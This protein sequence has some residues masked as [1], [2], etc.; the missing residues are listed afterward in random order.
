MLIAMMWALIISFAVVCF[1]LWAM[2]RVE[3][4]GYPANV[5]TEP[6]DLWARYCQEG[7]MRETGAA[8]SF[9]NTIHFDDLKRRAIV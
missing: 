2:G 6:E 1:G 8:L 9:L 3:K 7:C 4:D 5:E